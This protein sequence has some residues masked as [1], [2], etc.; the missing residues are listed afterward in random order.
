MIHVNEKIVWIT[1]ASSGIGRALTDIFLEK[2]ARVIVSDIN[3]EP[4]DELKNH[5]RG[6]ED[7]IEVLSLDV[8]DL[9]ALPQKYKTA[10]SF[11]GKIDILL[12]C[13]GVSQRSTVLDTDPE[14]IIKLININFCGAALLSKQV[15]PEMFE[16]KEGIIVTISSLASIAH[17][18]LR[19]AYSASK[20]ALN[21]FFDC[22]RAEVKSSGIDVLVV[23]PGFVQ[24]K[25]SQNALT[26]DGTKHGKFDSLQAEGITPEVC[27]DRIVG[28]IEK[29]KDVLVTGMGL[30]GY[31]I[32]FLQR[33]FPGLLR[34]ILQNAK[35]T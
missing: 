10:V 8:A 31:L 29:Q 1:G 23:I 4:L 22:L 9:K 21:G 33:I 32:L 35:V 15:L 17:S 3:T 19:S 13:A 5:I 28:A 11:Y 25:I 27:A 18:P 7:R 16:R 26:G 34:K 30:K 20:A 2:G 12:N 6:G 14:I 24:T